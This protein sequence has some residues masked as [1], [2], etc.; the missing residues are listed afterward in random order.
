VANNIQSDIV[1]W[2]EETLRVLD[3]LKGQAFAG[4]PTCFPQIDRN[5]RGLVRGATTIIAGAPGMGKTALLTNFVLRNA[6]AGTLDPA[7]QR[8]LM[9]SAE[10]GE[11]LWVERVIS[12][13]LG[14]PQGMLALGEAG[15]RVR[16]DKVAGKMQPINDDLTDEIILAADAVKKLPIELMGGGVATTFAIEQK[17]QELV[18]SRNLDV[19]LVIIDHVGALADVGESDSGVAKPD[20]ICQR[21][22]ALAQTYITHIISV[23]PLTKEGMS[24]KKIPSYQALRGS[25]MPGYQAANVIIIHSPRL[26]ELM[27]AER[28]F[29]GERVEVQLSIQ[30]NRFFGRYEVITEAFIPMIGR[31]EFNAKD[32]EDWATIYRDYKCPIVPMPNPITAPKGGNI[33]SGQSINLM[34]QAEQ[35]R[36]IINPGGKKE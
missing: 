28:G 17:L 7:R 3:L 32:D 12:L 26:A 34:A 2:A 19:P 36:K 23:W 31:F 16:W 21:L 24:G 27:M 14:V 5:I 18:C 30:K 35:M 25:V 10:M 4:L 8:I 29:V 15:N 9:V 6:G 11:V 20:L 22:D 1:F 33:V 13:L